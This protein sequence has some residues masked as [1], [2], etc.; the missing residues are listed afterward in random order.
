MKSVQQTSSTIKI[1]SLPHPKDIVRYCK[2]KPLLWRC[3][4]LTNPRSTNESE[5]FIC[6][7]SPLVLNR[8][9]DL[10]VKVR[11]SEP[12]PI[13]QHG[14]PENLSGLRA[15]EEQQTKQIQKGKQARC[16]SSPVTQVSSPCCKGNL[17]WSQEGQQHRETQRNGKQESRRCKGTLEPS[18]SRTG[19][20][21][22]VLY[23]CMC[24]HRFIM[25]G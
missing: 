23:Y 11:T 21:S 12:M 13:V 3:A 10:W 15:M 7:I 18:L 4:G 17:S 2:Y 9:I 5:I 1:F 16:F 19:L 24:H 8:T 20:F 6:L 22:R 25:N 14:L